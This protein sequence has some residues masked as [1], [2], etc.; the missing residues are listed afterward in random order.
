[1]S[2]VNRTR[3]GWSLRLERFG[4]AYCNF[5]VEAEGGLKGGKNWQDVL[6]RLNLLEPLRGS[7]KMPG[8]GGS[9]VGRSV[10]QWSIFRM[11]N[12]VFL[13]FSCS[14]FAARGTQRSL[15]SRW[16]DGIYDGRATNDASTAR[17]SSF[18]QPVRALS[19]VLRTPSVR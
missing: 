10:K 19:R 18:P 5:S 8:R 13:C 4:E 16:D 3:P 12:I 17:R 11:F 2:W 7:R 6:I 9:L 14:V 15:Q 1:M